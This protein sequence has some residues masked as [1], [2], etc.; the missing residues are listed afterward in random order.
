MLNRLLFVLVLL[1][2]LLGSSITLAKQ[3]LKVGVGNFPPFFIEKEQSGLFIEITEALFSELPEYDISFV[4]MS[5]NRLHHEI[6]SGRMIDVACNIF[7]ESNVTAYLSTPIFRYRDVAISRKSDKLVINKIADLQGKSIAAYQGAKDLLGADFKKMTVNNPKYTEYSRPS[8]T[9]YLFIAGQK[10]L[11]IGD[12]NIFW[13]D[14][15]HKYLTSITKT[16]TED[17]TV[18]R[19]WPDVY[20]H[21]A[22]KDETIRDAIDKAIKKLTLNGVIKKIHAKYNFINYNR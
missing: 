6:N 19:L 22:F 14:L 5:N 17:F 4:F 9:T 10:E 8:E 16:A 13:H 11:R 2:L 7:A 15:E 3:T 20:S 18:H 1:S 12:V 21:M